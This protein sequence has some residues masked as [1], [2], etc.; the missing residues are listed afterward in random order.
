MIDMDDQSWLKIARN[1]YR[2]Q[3]NQRDV[4][5]HRLRF[6]LTAATLLIAADLSL[7]ASCPR[8]WQWWVLGLFSL[9]S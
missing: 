2:H 8:G 3:E 7:M 6:L 1:D 5:F 4:L 9:A